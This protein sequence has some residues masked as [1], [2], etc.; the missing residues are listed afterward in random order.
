MSERTLITLFLA[1]LDQVG[2]PEV[3]P[4]LRI[5]QLPGLYIF[6]GEYPREHHSQ[7]HGRASMIL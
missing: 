1:E 5:C 4:G 6:S 3:V 2:P 7:D